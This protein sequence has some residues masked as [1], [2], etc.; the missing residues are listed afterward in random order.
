MIWCACHFGSST[1]AV[2]RTRWLVAADDR[3]G[4]FDA[5]GELASGLGPVAIRCM[6]TDAPDLADLDGVV[7]D[8]G[9]RHMPPERAAAIAGAVPFAD[10]TWSAH[11]IDSQLRGN[12]ATEL[13]ARH[14]TTGVRVLVVPAWPELHRVCVDGVV[15]VNGTPVADGPAG[16]DPR[17]PVR[18]SR[19]AEHLRSAG[20]TDVT[21]VCATDDLDAWLAGTSP[22][23]VCDAATGADIDT[24][25]RWWA[26][27]TA[28]VLLA[29][30]GGPIGAAARA[31]GDGY[32]I[33]QPQPPVFGHHWLIVCG[34]LHPM[35]RR[36]IHALTRRYPHVMVVATDQVEQKAVVGHDDANQAA[37][38]LAVRAADRT[39]GS[40]VSTMLIIGGDTAAAVIGDK[41]W[42]VW[43][44]AGPGLPYGRATDGTGP[45][46]ITKAGGF[47]DDQTLVDLYSTFGGHS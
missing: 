8:L 21:A 26:A 31:M 38:D 35:A 7:V 2:T 46:V 23:A 9:T 44:H 33:E 18:S 10:R 15:C 45:W 25:A 19:P 39:A 36:Q 28:S 37:R 24:I 11:K 12:W 47:G 29:A 22:F 30:P 4:A 16:H 27:H 41:P 40:M 43:G 6:D 42:T 32:Q 14:R 17:S 3:T 1:Y 5:A 34:S 13:V 20:A